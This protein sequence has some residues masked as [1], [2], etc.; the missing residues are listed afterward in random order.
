MS[1]SKLTPAETYREIMAPSGVVPDGV[2]D[3]QSSGRREL[4]QNGKE[5]SAC[6]MTQL[7]EART[8]PRETWGYYPDVPR[9]AVNPAPDVSKME[10]GGAAIADAMNKE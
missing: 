3:N 4:W 9:P 10:M 2:Y 6:S 8:L 5:H 7:R 1:D